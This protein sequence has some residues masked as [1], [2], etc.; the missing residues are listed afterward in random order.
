M[1]E[2][3]SSREPRMWGE[4]SGK[5]RKSRRVGSLKTTSFT[6]SI[7]FP[8]PFM[9]PWN[10][11]RW[12]VGRYRVARLKCLGAE[13][14]LQI[15]QIS[16]AFLLHFKRPWSISVRVKKQKVNTSLPCSLSQ[17]INQH[18][19]S[20]AVWK[21]NFFLSLPPHTSGNITENE[22]HRHWISQAHGF[23]IFQ[24]SELC[25][26]IWWPTGGGLHSCECVRQRGLGAY[27][28]I[29][30]IFRGQLKESELEPPLL[31]C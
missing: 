30:S 13:R 23:P 12:S 24:D 22:G 19:T 31:W 16:L 3:I 27:E 8:S 2:I 11:T 25:Y 7:C 1:G 4:N 28:I 20:S 15:A 17:V 18:S 14:S 9:P 6:I 5:K 10:E 21:Y 26:G 29:C